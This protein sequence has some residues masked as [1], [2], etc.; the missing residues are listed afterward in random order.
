[1]WK[2]LA[3]PS[4]R[5]VY[6]I[7]LG[8]PGAP[9]AGL[10][11]RLSRHARLIYE[12][13]DPA[14]PLLANQR[15]PKAEV[16][17]ASAMDRHL[18]AFADRLVFRG[19]YLAE[20]FKALVGEGSMP[21]WDWV[22][23]GVD[24]GLFRPLRQEASVAALRRKHRLENCFVVGLV[25]NIHHNRLHNLFYGWELVEALSILRP[26]LPIIGVVVGDGPG[27]GVLE[28]TARA[29]GVADRL[30]LVGRVRHSDVPLWMNVFDVAL[31]TQTDDP[32]GWGRTTAKLPEYLACGT[33]V[34]CTDVGEAHRLLK[35]SGQTLRYR[36]MRDGVY[37]QRLAARIQ[38][39]LETDLDVLRKTNRE[40]ALRLFDY[41]VLR[42]QMHMILTKAT[43]EPK[44]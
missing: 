3:A 32:V 28:S 17:L 30:R 27:V 21:T 16:V 8:I 33:P 19:S 29:L 41:R 10:R 24:T 9:L 20:Y 31:S 13:G 22:P 1:M 36:G 23:D 38:E 44:T 12:I 11:R 6:C 37:P 2:A 18:P 39:L 7:D 34:I 5:W 14:K 42:R 40:L 4:L 26:E 35:E 43:T 15:R 25:G